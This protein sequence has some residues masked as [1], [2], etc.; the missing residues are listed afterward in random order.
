[1]KILNKE[2]LY[3]FLIFFIT[4]LLCR[5]FF[6]I[7]ILSHVE[8]M[9]NDFVD[10]LK[11]QNEQVYD[12]DVNII[13]QKIIPVSGFQMTLDLRKW[14]ETQFVQN[15]KLYLDVMYVHKILDQKEDMKQG[16]IQKTFDER[17]KKWKPV[18]GID[19]KS[20]TPD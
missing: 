4:L 6:A 2:W 10:Y 15:K 8:H 16:E 11:S 1:M 17:F 3:R 13:V 20:N 5:A 14:R 9:S 7:S 12:G 18:E 19:V